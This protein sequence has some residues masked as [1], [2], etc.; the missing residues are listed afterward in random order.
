LEEVGMRK[1]AGGTFGVSVLAA[2]VG[3]FMWSS[4]VTPNARIAKS[5]DASTAA[6]SVYELTIERGRDLPVE[7]WEPA[8]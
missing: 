8:F 4:E 2:G 5:A 7:N 6:L 3:I 1:I